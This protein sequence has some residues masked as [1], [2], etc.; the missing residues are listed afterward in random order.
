MY[1][2]AQGAG[3]DIMEGNTT[4]AAGQTDS[5]WPFAIEYEETVSGGP[6]CFRYTNG[7]ETDAV[8]VEPGDGTCVCGYRNYGLE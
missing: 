1:S 3:G 2:T 6:Q 8:T 4:A 7:Q 5:D